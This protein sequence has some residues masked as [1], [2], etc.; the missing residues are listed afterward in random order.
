VDVSA[1]FWKDGDPPTELGPSGR[2]NFKSMVI[3]KF[4]VQPHTI[5][6]SSIPE[7][8]STNG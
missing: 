4:L 3:T 5:H 1:L 6:Q 7:F 2:G 8:D